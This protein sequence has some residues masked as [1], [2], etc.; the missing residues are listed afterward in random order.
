MKCKNYFWIIGGGQLQA[1]LIEEVSRLGMQSIVTDISSE[2]VC[3]PLADLFFDLDIFDIDAHIELANRLTRQG[4]KVAGVLAA[5]VDAPETMARLARHLGLPSVDPEIAKLVHNKAEFRVRL[6]ELGY[7]VPHFE[8]ITKATLHKL[9]DIV[10]AIGIPLIIKNSDSSGS[11]GTRI[12]H[13]YNLALMEETALAAMEIS[14]SGIALIE[15]CWE[16]S[17]HTVETIFDIEG[18]FHPC[19]ITDRHFDRSN[20]YALEVG[21]RHP[22]VLSDALQSEMFSIA[23]NVATDLGVNL[24]AAKYDFIV[25]SEGPRI[26]EMTVRLSGGYDCQYLVP[27]TTGKSILRAAVKTAIGEKFDNSYLVDRLHLVGVT[28]SLWP[29]QGVIKAINGVDVA[30][31]L[32]GIEKI[33][34]RSKVGDFIEPYIDCTRRTCFIIATGVS[35]FEARENLYKAEQAINIEILEEFK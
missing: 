2:C 11:R 13:E 20:G 22:S 8:T 14:K 35:E 21:L 16:G 5:G 29:K 18:N 9:A 27:A 28:G 24:G 30:L 6:R 12:F 26:I 34:F 23:K 10:S 25:T 33:F 32:P 7:P 15:S 3:A 1:P 4:I 19:F 17:E 31:N